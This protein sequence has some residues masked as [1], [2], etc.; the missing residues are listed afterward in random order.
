MPMN[1]L[2]GT[3]IDVGTITLGYIEAE[4]EDPDSGTTATA[5]VHL[6]D[7]MYTRPEIDGMILFALDPQGN[8]HDW[9]IFIG[10]LDQEPTFLDELEPSTI[11]QHTHQ[12][13]SDSTLNKMLP[14]ITDPNMKQ[15][16]INQTTGEVI[17]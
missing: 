12:L 8:H 16:M 15:D 13:F 9:G 7:V 2:E 5:I 4:Y 17:E 1:I 14:N 11:P 6:P 10:F 3:I